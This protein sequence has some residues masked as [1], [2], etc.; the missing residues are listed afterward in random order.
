[1]NRYTK[2]VYQLV[3]PAER[4]GIFLEVFAAVRN[5]FWWQL[6]LDRALLRGIWRVWLL[7][8]VLATAMRRGEWK[9]SML[10]HNERCMIVWESAWK[11]A[12]ECTTSSRAAWVHSSLNFMNIL[13]KMLAPFSFIAKTRREMKD[14]TDNSSRNSIV[15]GCSAQLI[16][17]H[18]SSGL[19]VTDE[20]RAFAAA[21]Y[22]TAL[23]I[24]EMRSLARFLLCKRCHDLFHSIAQ[25]GRDEAD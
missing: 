11:R 3:S 5:S 18:L 9:P 6:I 2:M 10:S 24:H 19:T 17:S 22:V 7:L 1:M 20:V 23:R 21:E 8:M 4:N 25:L 14:T 12:S 15:M 13:T 16:S